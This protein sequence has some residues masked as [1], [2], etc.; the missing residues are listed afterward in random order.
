MIEHL[1]LIGVD[2]AKNQKSFILDTCFIIYEIEHGNSSRL[3]DFCKNNLLI[4]SSFNFQELEKVET[5]I[6]GM[7]SRVHN[8][9]KNNKIKRL[10]VNVSPGNR[11][12]EINFSDEVDKNILKIVKDPSD[13]VLVACGILTRS[14]ILTRDKHH[15]FTIE[16]ENFIKNYNIS[17]LNN[18][19]S[20]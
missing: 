14:D 15:L 13:A 20:L 18:F 3:R 5:R 11:D 19:H 10:D 12:S 6:H 17:I 16:L 2:E 1:E 8:F 4:I 9:L 7:K